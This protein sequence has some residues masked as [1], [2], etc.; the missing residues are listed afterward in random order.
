ME[1]KDFVAITIG[2]IIDG[3]LA[4]QNHAEPLG[5]FVSPA[6]GNASIAGRIMNRTGEGR[7]AEIP[8]MG[9][10]LHEIQMVEFDVAVT[11]SDGTTSTGGVGVAKI[12]TLGVTRESESSTESVSRIRFK[13]PIAYPHQGAAKPQPK[14]NPLLPAQ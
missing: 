11:I 1:L 12:V 8:G 2:Q 13:V 14:A 7:W 6:D 10:H 9:G 3:V 5:A 4:A